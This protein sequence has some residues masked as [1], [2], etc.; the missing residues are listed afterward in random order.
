LGDWMSTVSDKEMYVNSV[1]SHEL[2]VEFD[3]TD[4]FLTW[5]SMNY[6]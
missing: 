1:F 3:S 4:E 5:F 6:G 2:Y